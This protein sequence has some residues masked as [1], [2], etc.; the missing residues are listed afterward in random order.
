M[1]SR[2]SLLAAWRARRGATSAMLAAG[3]GLALGFAALATEAGGWYLAQ[4]NAVT[5]ADL[6]ALAG[7]S[8][9]DRG[10]AAEPVARDTAARN[11]FAA[12]DGVQVFNPPGS[13]ALLGNAAAVEVVV[14]QRQAMSLA[15][16]FLGSAPSIRARAVALAQADQPVCLLALQGGLELGGNSTTSAQRCVLGSNAAAPGGINIYGSARVRAAGLVTTGACSGCNGGDVWTDDTRTARPQAI[17][18]RPDPITDPFAG[19][20]SWS[21]APPACRTG[22]IDLNGNNNSSRTAAIAPG[23]G[24]ICTSLS[25]GPRETLTLA[26]GLYYFNNASL[27]IRG[28]VSGSGVTLVFTGNV[29]TV[30]TLRINADSATTLTGPAESLIA[31]HAEGAGLIVYR[32]A[33]ATNNGNANEVRLN[34]GAAMRLT[35]GL[36]F[37]SSDV[38]VNGNS[39]ALASSCMAVVGYRLSFSGTADTQVDVS[40]CPGFSRYPVLRIVRLVE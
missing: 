10:A 15:T 29:D 35:G 38:A 25:V 5:A 4:R 18:N 6:A 20:Q 23:E 19:L 36:Y 22:A 14:T 21:P 33:V 28:T 11:G 32:D 34:G 16:L 13:G 9:R 7:A 26:P 31:G 37:P 39:G 2:A 30:G 40:G 8:A 3:A 27:D 1:L 24:A 12:A 17:A